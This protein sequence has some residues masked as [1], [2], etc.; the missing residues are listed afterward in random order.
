MRKIVDGSIITVCKHRDLV[1]KQVNLP[2]LARMC[3]QT[4]V[5]MRHTRMCTVGNAETS[6]LHM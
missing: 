3:P 6:Q 5:H 4:N 2:T 1:V